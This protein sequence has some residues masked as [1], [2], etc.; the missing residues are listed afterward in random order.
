[1]WPSV[2]IITA[3]ASCLNSAVRLS[4]NILIAQPQTC[5][6]KHLT[7]LAWVVECVRWLA[8]RYRIAPERYTLLCICPEM[9]VENCWGVRTSKPPAMA[10]H[11]R[12]VWPRCGRW[13]LIGMYFLGAQNCST[14]K[15]ETNGWVV[16]FC[17]HPHL[18]TNYGW[19]RLNMG[20]GKDEQG[21]GGI[22]PT[23]YFSYLR[24][25]FLRLQ[26]GEAQIKKLGWK[27]EKGAYVHVY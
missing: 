26:I 15:E 5:T 12:N 9:S 11:V 1:V 23:Q 21:W 17:E 4:S 7:E 20:R 6:S 16:R 27:W 25:V 3:I 13:G 19:H 10:C 18:K 14:S 2:I 22:P 24:I 8:D